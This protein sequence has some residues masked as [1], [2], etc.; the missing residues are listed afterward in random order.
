MSYV[1]TDLLWTVSS[2]PRT[3]PRRVS[4]VRSTTLTFRPRPGQLA[5][6]RG[7]AVPWIF[8]IWNFRAALVC[9]KCWPTDPRGCLSV[10]VV[11]LPA[12]SNVAL[13][14]V[15]GRFVVHGNFAQSVKNWSIRKS[16]CSSPHL[17]DGRGRIC[18]ETTNSKTLLFLVDWKV[19]S[20]RF[21]G[22]KLF[23]VC[24]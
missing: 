4:F 21:A 15:Y 2:I 16:V 11:C 8:E 24:F 19:S 12:P 1:E 14:A 13:K 10:L 7:G 22:K 17:R 6:E 3:G 20:S 5:S 23:E 18:S 9:K